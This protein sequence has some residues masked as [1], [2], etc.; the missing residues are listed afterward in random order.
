MEYNECMGLLARTKEIIF[1]DFETEGLSPE[2]CLPIQLAAIKVDANTLKVLDTLNIYLNPNRPL[3]PK[4]TEITGITDEF[5]LS[6]GVLEKDAFP[7]IYEF[8]GESPTVCGHNI[9]YFD[10]K[11]LTALYNRHGK[12]IYLK[13]MDT[14]L[15]A[16]QLIPK[17]EIG[18]HKL[19]SVAEFY[20]IKDLEFHN[21]FDDTKACLEIFKPLMI[22]SRKKFEKAKKQNLGFP[23]DFWYYKGYRGQERVYIADSLGNKVYYDNRD[24]SYGIKDSDIEHYNIEAFEKSITSKYGLYISDL[25]VRA[26]QN[27]IDKYSSIVGKVF[28]F[29]NEEEL[30]SKVRYFKNNSLDIV[31]TDDTIRVVKFSP[32]R[33]GKEV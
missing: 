10:N 12:T 13:S 6:N 29:T 1:Y 22:E 33:K 19:Q 2:T 23:V 21:A 31:V 3:E 5:L 4:I 15:L 30:K 14:L 32:S 18:S 26:K 25:F 11:F 16:R 9:K 7:K 8:F 20:Q 27:W 24:K 17:K 28:S